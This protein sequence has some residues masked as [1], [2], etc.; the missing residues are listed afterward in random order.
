MK[1]AGVIREVPQILL[2]TKHMFAGRI[3]TEEKISVMCKTDKQ[4][5]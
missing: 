3:R 1:N 4:H 5:Q 2:D